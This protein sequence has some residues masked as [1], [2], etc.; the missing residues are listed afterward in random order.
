MLGQVD[1]FRR[2]LATPRPWDALI[3]EFPMLRIVAWNLEDRGLAIGPEEA[4]RELTK[5][6]ERYCAEWDRFPVRP[7]GWRFGTPEV[8]TDWRL[9][10]AC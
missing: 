10:H 1:T 4:Q 7:P 8:T 3:G 2:A 6:V 9:L 5:L